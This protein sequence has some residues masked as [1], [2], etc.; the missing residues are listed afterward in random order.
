MLWMDVTSLV[1]AEQKKA[2]CSRLEC[3]HCN[4]WLPTMYIT[5]ILKDMCLV[6]SGHLLKERPYY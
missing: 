3:M 5:Y 1:Q 2:C 4:R 6:L